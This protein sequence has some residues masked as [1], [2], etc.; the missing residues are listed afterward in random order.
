MMTSCWL[1]ALAWVLALIYPVSRCRKEERLMQQTFGDEYRDYMDKVGP[2]FPFPFPQW[3][4]KVYDVDYT[5]LVSD[6][7]FII[8]DDDDLFNINS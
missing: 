7:D 6:N 1:W 2:F 3:G 8:E 4:N 5:N